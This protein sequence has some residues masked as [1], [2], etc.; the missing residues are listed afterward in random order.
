MN[1]M[2]G[3]GNQIAVCC[4]SELQHLDK[5][6][7][8]L[9]DNNQQHPGPNDEDSDGM[10]VMVMSHDNTNLSMYDQSKD[11]GLSSML[12]DME[13]DAL[14][15]WFST[16]QMIEMANSIARRDTDWVSHTIMEHDIW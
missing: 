3:R 11:H 6:L 4:R 12:P 14:D 2:V 13:D 7:S 10:G 8:R 1:E 16:A 5:M 15:T 9:R